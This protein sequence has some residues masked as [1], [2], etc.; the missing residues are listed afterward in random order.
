[1]ISELYEAPVFQT[2]YD[3]LNGDFGGGGPVQTGD[4]SGFPGAYIPKVWAMES[5]RILKENM[6]V[7]NLVHRDFQ[8]E[9]ASYGD[10]VHTRRPGEMTVTRR[11]GRHAGRQP[12]P[13]GAGHRRAGAVEPVVQQDLHHP[14]R[15]DEQV[16]PGTGANLP[17]AGHPVH[18]PWRGSCGLGPARQR[19]PRLVQ[20]AGWPSQQPQTDTTVYDACVRADE[21][22]NINKAP[23]VGRSLLL[24]PERQGDHVAVRQVRQGDGAR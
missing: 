22:L 13:D 5:L 1:M 9:V 23:E 3:A 19:L 24:A 20:H 4:T 7:S 16:L 17:G 18:R 14:R 6:G 2:C 15:R 12:A 21:V 11:D 10:L 8:N